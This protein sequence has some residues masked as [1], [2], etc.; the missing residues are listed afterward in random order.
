MVGVRFCRFSDGGGDGLVVVDLPGRFCG[1]A[2]CGVSVMCLQSYLT[3]LISVP[4][5]WPSG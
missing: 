5:R 3:V 4:P 1:T 2:V